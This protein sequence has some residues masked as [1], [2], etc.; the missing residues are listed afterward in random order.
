[1]TQTEVII[2]LVIAFATFIMIAMH[3]LEPKQ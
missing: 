3:Y 2:I 1:M